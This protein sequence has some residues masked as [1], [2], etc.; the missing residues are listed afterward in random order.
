VDEILVRQIG[1]NCSVE[2]AFAVFTDAIDLWWP[3]GHRKH[4][5]GRLRLEPR[6]GGALVDRAPD[7]SEWTMGRVTSINPPLRLDLDWYP[8]SP[9]AP[10]SVEVRFTPDGTGTAITV[11]HRP[12]LETKSIWSQRVETFTRGWDAVL[13]ALKSY[14]EET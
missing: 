1:L 14:I 6:D 10:T 8:G 12:L 3:R 2:H 9:A 4:R 13:P 5:E 11:T 7:G